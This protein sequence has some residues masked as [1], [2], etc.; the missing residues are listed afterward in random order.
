MPRSEPL[1]PL[2][3]HGSVTQ[4][5]QFGMAALV[6]FFDGTEPSLAG[7]FAF[8]LPPAI[9][10]AERTNAVGRFETIHC[11]QIVKIVRRRQQS[12]SAIID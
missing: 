7:P 9:H 1:Q 12:W 4:I 8:R 5:E 2:G 3:E 6:K 10:H 11:D